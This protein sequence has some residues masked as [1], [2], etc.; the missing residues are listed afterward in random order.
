MPP[1]P[2]TTT[3]SPADGRPRRI[4]CT[5][6]DIGWAIAATSPLRRRFV[7]VDARAGRH[8]RLLRQGAVAVEPDREVA[9]AQVG[10][11]I[12]AVGAHTARHA[13][14][15]GDEVTL[16]EPTDVATGGDD[17]PGELV[18]R[19]HRSAMSGHGVGGVDREHRRAVGELGGVGAA[20]PD[21]GDRE[22]QLVV[23]RHRRGHVLDADVE[24]AV[25][26]RRLHLSPLDRRVQSIVMF[27]PPRARGNREGTRVCRIHNAPRSPSS[28]SRRSGATRCSSP[29]ARWASATPTS[30]SSPT[31]T[32]SPSS[33]RSSQVTSGRA[34]SSRSARRCATCVR[35][36][37][38]SASARSTAAPTTS[39]SRS[40]ERPP[41]DSRSAPTGPTASPTSCPG[42]RAPRSS[43][44]A[45][46]STPSA[47]SAGSSPATTWRCSVAGRSDSAPS[48][49]RA[50]S[51]GA[52]C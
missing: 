29:P 4:A 7:D 17:G 47:A 16:G 45:A 34:R 33:S 46:P 6:I 23:G 27:S 30:T 25:I 52:R 36:T 35:A 14:A 18:A 22:Q 48:P 44:S 11:P 43:R 1:A 21:G 3:W 49:P 12:A 28:T 8:G 37:A 20:D 10:P 24:P 9:S 2:M 40:A 42:S 38:S 31:A 39:G 50:P 32:S 51:A 13:G 26:A 19:C 15:R 5:A 41:S